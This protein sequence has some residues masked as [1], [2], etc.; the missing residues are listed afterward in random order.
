M[1]C[2]FPVSFYCSGGRGGRI[3]DIGNWPVLGERLPSSSQPWQCPFQKGGTRPPESRSPLLRVPLRA[4]FSSIFSG[5]W[6]RKVGALRRQGWG[7]RYRHALP[8]RAVSGALGDSRVLE[9]HPFR[10][11]SIKT[12]PSPASKETKSTPRP[13]RGALEGIGPVG[14]RGCLVKFPQIAPHPG[15]VVSSH[16]LLPCLSF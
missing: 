4:P 10:W 14:G 12:T 7:G 16:F 3:S 1:P 5:L 2:V 8:G 11:L 15:S 13:H 6:C 9:R